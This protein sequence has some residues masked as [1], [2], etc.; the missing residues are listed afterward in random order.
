MDSRC[1]TLARLKLLTKALQG[2]KNLPSS[3]SKACLSQG[4]LA[5]YVYDSEGIKPMALNTLKSCADQYI[6][7]GGW[8]KLDSMRKSYLAMRKNIKSEFRTKKNTSAQHKDMLTELLNTL[9]LER[10]YRIQIQVAYEA[11]LERL[12]MMSQTDPELVSFI[13]RHV[14]VFSFKRITLTNKSLDENG[15]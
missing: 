8:K 6:E 3:F 13:N 15:N 5:K 10:R 4:G 7:D 14:S 11:I 9:D 1:N 12:R 2:D